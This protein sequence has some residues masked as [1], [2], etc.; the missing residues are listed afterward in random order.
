MK[1]DLGR[2]TEL[3]LELVKILKL[4]FRQ[5]FGAEYCSAFCCRCFEEVMVEIL[6]LALAKILNFKFS[7]DADIWLRFL[8]DALSRF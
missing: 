2:D 6:K 1:L 3:K 7:G 8:G 5:D 4:R